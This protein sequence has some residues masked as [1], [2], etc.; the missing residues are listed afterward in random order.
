MTSGKNQNK[1]IARCNAFLR[2]WRNDRRG[3]SAIEFALL[4]PLMLTIY[5]GAVEISNLLTIDRKVA[6][7]A[8]TTADLVAQA[9]ILN[10]DAIADVFLAADEVKF[11]GKRMRRT[12]RI[13]QIELVREVADAL[14]S[15][16]RRAR[17]RSLRRSNG[18]R[19]G[20]VN[21]G[22]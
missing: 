14:E 6:N 18:I 1:L 19:T 16:R 12:A 17:R 9:Q 5:F 15:S 21:V 8:G 10:D 2:R 11:A 20:S 4:F 22:I 7:V 3:L 13:K